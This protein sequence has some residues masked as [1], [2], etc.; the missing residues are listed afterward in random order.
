MLVAVLVDVKLVT[1]SLKRRVASF[2]CVSK[3]EQ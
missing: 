2:Q 3:G 1:P